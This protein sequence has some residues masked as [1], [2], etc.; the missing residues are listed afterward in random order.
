MKKVLSRKQM[1]DLG[2]P[3]RLLRSISSNPDLTHLFF[4]SGTGKTSNTYYFPEKVDRW[5]ELREDERMAREKDTGRKGM[6]RKS[7]DAQLR[8]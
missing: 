6:L 1:M 2:Y 8:R 5:L 3:E 4:R 7:D